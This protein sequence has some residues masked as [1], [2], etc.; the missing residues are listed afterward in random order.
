MADGTTETID[1]PLTLNYEGFIVPLIKAVQDIVNISST[2]QTN[3]IAWLGNASNGIGDLYAIVI[4]ATTG[5]FQQVCL[6]DTIDYVATDQNG[7][8]ATST[9]TVIVSAPQ[10][11]NDNQVASSSTAMTTSQ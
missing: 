5:N 1:N 3:L 9:R 10:A 8:A 6:T 4:H 7:L 11:A 2:F